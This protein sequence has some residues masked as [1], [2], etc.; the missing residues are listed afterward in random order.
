MKPESYTTVAAVYEWLVPESMLTPDGAA[1]AY[2]G[3]FDE[4]GPDAR[5]LDCAAGTG[6]LAVGLRLKGLDVTAT[7]ASDAMIART[8]ELAAAH[9]VS[10]DASVC[11]WEQLG[12]RG[13]SSS[14][15]AVWCTGNSLAHAPGRARRRAALGQMAAVLRPGGLL[16]LTS[17]NWEFVRGQGSGLKISEELVERGGRRAV[18]VYGWSLADDWDERHHLDIAVAIVEPTGKIDSHVERLP[19]WPFRYED[20]H[21]DLRAA[22]LATTVSTY[23]PGVDRYLVAAKLP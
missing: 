15:D 9:G 23:D 11:E 1:D 12:A 3:I 7:D 19:F 14:F 4:L 2:A 21:A 8:R 18:V 22:G 10:L 13:W 16:V 20:L 17:R 6:E 5:V